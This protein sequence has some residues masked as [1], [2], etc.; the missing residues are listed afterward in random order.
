MPRL[1]SFWGVSPAEVIRYDQDFADVMKMML[2]DAVVRM[3]HPSPVV[4][5]FSNVDYE[6]L[7]KPRPDI[8]I[9]VEGDPRSAIAWPDFSPPLG[10]GFQMYSGVKQQMR[11]A[12]GALGAIQGL[13]LGSKRFS[14]TE[15]SRTFDAALDRPELFAQVVEREFLPQIGKYTLELYQ[16]NLGPETEEIQKRVGE[17]TIPAVLADILP[18][19]DVEYVGS[20][21]LNDSQQADSFREIIAAS[22]NPLVSQLIPWIP[23]LQ[24]YFRKIGADEVAA[25][26]GNPDLV[27]LHL[28]LT[29]LAGPTNAL[30]GNNN[31][32]TPSQPP[33]GLL[34]AQ[35]AGQTQ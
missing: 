20:R 18:G 31:Q 5:K 35:I 17:S 3:T 30:S 9:R 10:P 27:K 8:P 1:G 6:R 24:K 28:T 2:A 7:R 19:F 4:N 34:P 11:E 12:S 21:L 14:A 22:A 32:T 13:G 15:A 33:S 25:M 16:E 29:Q 26:V 23:L